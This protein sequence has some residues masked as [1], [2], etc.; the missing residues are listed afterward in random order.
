MT[1]EAPTTLTFA[2]LF[3]AQ[4][5]DFQGL[6]TEALEVLDQAINDTPTLADLSARMPSRIP[7]STSF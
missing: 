7:Y 4:H 3:F 6:W 5:L 2:Q 1:E